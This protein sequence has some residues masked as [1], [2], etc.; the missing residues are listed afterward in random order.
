MS[1]HDTRKTLQQMFDHA[2][3]A[4]T[5]AQGKTREDLDADRTFEWRNKLSVFARRLA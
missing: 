3:E 5:L 4:M 2:R 1:R